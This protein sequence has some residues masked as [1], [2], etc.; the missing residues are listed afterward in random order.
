MYTDVSINGENISL[1][2]ADTDLRYR[3]IHYEINVC[4]FCT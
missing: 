1:V 4:A 2:L 3:A